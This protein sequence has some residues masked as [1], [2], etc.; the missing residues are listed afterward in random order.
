MESGFLSRIGRD[1]FTMPS[2]AA[3]MAGA[4]RWSPQCSI[5]ALFIG[6]LVKESVALQV[7]AAVSLVITSSIAVLSLG[8]HGITGMYGGAAGAPVSRLSLKSPNV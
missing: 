4:A 1:L 6:S 2:S 7:H 3:S 5:E 8:A